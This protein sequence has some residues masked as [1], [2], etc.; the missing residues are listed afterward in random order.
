MFE[1]WN[2]NNRTCYYLSLPFKIIGIILSLPHSLTLKE[3]MR[4]LVTAL[5]AYG[6]DSPNMLPCSTLDMQL[7]CI[8]NMMTF[9]DGWGDLWLHVCYLGMHAWQTA[10][11]HGDA[12]EI[13]VRPINML[14]DMLIRCGQAPW[15]LI[16]H[17]VIKGIY[18]MKG[19]ASILALLLI[20]WYYWLLTQQERYTA[21]SHVLTQ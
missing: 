3:H 15:D 9:V 7:I 19:I 10:V 21:Y 1:S 16:L 4:A 8:Q 6:D 11:K 13:E 14:H 12:C 5:E 20:M 2:Y 18:Y 17:H